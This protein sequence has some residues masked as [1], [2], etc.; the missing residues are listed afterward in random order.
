MHGITNFFVLI[1]PTPLRVRYSTIID[2]HIWNTETG[3]HVLD[4]NVNEMSNDNIAVVVVV[5][6]EYEVI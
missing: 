5:V 2:C 1:R 3:T 6:R 4:A